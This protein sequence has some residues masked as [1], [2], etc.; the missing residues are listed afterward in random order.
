MGLIKVLLKVI[1]VPIVVIAVII[2]AIVI[3][4]KIH[5]DRKKE[6]KQARQR[7]AELPP[8]SQWVYPDPLQVQSPVQKPA[9][10]AYPIYTTPSHMEAGIVR[11]Q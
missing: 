10:V 1:L 7:A 11:Q 4:I 8:L 2:A 6:A 5:R 9:P 3:C